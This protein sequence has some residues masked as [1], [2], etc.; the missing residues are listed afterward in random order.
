MRA[1]SGS[2]KPSI[3]NVPAI[4][5]S[6]PTSFAQRPMRCGINSIPLLDFEQGR[7]YLRQIKW[8]LTA[9]A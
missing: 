2:I 7:G 5:F 6:R 8:P 4:T 1:F 3:A 9:I